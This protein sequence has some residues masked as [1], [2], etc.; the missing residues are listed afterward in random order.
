MSETVIRRDRPFV[1]LDDARLTGA[2]PARLYQAPVE[3]IEARDIA[4]VKPALERLRA[5]RHRGLH[6]AG[7]LAYE[8]ASAFEPV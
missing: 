3:I 4:A 6:A 1:L 8:A 7:F 5:A 2:A